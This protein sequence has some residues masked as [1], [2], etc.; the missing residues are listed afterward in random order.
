MERILKISRGLSSGKI[1]T[2]DIS[3]E[4]LKEISEKKLEGWEMAD[5][6]LYGKYDWRRG[7]TTKGRI[8]RF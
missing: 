7:E 6:I 3:T 5:E 4:D 2:S 1:K 8:S